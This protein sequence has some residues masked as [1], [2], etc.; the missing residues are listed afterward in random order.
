MNNHF[1]PEQLKTAFKGRQSIAMHFTAETVEF[2]ASGSNASEYSTVMAAN[3]LPDGR[4][5]SVVTMHADAYDSNWTMFFK[6][7]R[8]GDRV[9]FYLQDNTPISLKDSHRFTEIVARVYRP[10]EEGQPGVKTRFHLT[11]D[12][13]CEKL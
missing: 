5:G 3:A 2:V 7:I 8:K 4:K 9:W 1:T 12:T 6:S 11:V 10:I 13:Y